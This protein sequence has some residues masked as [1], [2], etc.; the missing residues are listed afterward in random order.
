MCP[1]SSDAFPAEDLV[2]RDRLLHR[3]GGLVPR[4]LGG[5]RVTALVAGEAGIGKT[6]LL[7]ATAAMAAPGMHIGW[8]GCVD[9]DGAPGYWPWTQAL[10]GLARSVGLEQAREMAADDLGLLASIVPSL[11][12]PTH[13]EMDDRGRLL[14]MDATSRFIER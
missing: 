14:L 1:V 7:R 4:V 13:D 3:L 8:G 10:D 9:A 5:A 6:S 12:A 2:G 11:G